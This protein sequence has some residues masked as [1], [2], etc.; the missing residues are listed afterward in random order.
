MFTC[1]LVIRKK[2]FENQNLDKSRSHWIYINAEQI[3]LLPG[4]SPYAVFPQF[5]A[6]EKWQDL[7][8]FYF[9]YYS[10][11]CF[12]LIAK[13]I[14][15]CIAITFIFISNWS[16]NLKLW[17]M[18]NCLWKKMYFCLWNVFLSMK[19]MKWNYLFMKNSSLSINCISMKNMF[20]SLK[21][22]SVYK[23]SCLWEY[24]V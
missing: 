19:W 20:C 17:S 12:H 9:T 11:F 23:M 8:D 3:R 1:K 7:T 5:P 16:H 15:I 22:C 2:L 14:F 4:F 18:V 6:N 21:I 13:K 24:P 10:Y